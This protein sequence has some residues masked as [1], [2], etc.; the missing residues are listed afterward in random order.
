VD[1]AVRLRE[2]LLADP[3]QPVLLH[4]DLHQENILSARRQT[5]LAI[6]PKGVLGEATYEPT[7]FLYNNLPENLTAPQLKALL[8]RRIDQFA[9]ELALDRPRLR[10]WAVV[11]CVLSGW[12][13]Y[14]DHGHGWENVISIASLL[15]DLY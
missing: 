12:W 3:P 14:E 1:R 10:S 9:E 15:S 8:E 5:W 4:A 13:S 6:D 7:P 2:E 11:Q